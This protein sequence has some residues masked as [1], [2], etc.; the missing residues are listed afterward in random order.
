MKYVC[1]FLLVTDYIVF[2]IYFLSGII[3][4]QEKKYTCALTDL[5]FAV[6]TCKPLDHSDQEIYYSIV[7]ELYHCLNNHK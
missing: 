2:R 4:F 1:F 7:D 5:M 3:Y 6:R